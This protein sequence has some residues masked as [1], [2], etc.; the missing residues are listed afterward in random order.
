MTYSF[1]LWPILRGFKE[2]RLMKIQIWSYYIFSWKRINLYLYNLIVYLRK[3][4][5]F[6]KYSSKYIITTIQINKQ[7][8]NID[9]FETDGDRKNC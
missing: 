8:N 4:T 2:I 5:I 9:L 1:Y 6:F 7:I 3:K